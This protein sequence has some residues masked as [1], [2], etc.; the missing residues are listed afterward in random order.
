MGLQEEMRV[1][2][3]LA[4]IIFHSPVRLR[5]VIG[6][7]TGAHYRTLLMFFI[8]PH[9]LKFAGTPQIRKN[10]VSILVPHFHTSTQNYVS[11]LAY[12]RKK[13]R[14]SRGMFFLASARV[15]I[16]SRNH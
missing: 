16:D 6:V 7:M 9:K 15:Y 5:P 11:K 4:A 1:R 10:Y 3:W 13:P 2:I 14:H 8:S 12:V